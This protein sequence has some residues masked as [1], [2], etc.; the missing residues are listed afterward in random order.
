MFRETKAVGKDIIVVVDN[1]MM[2]RSRRNGGR[3]RNLTVVV[4]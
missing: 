1:L 3:G 4:Q 2:M